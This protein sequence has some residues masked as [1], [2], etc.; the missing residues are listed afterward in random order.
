M[1]QTIINALFHGNVNPWERKVAHNPKR[2]EVERKI[3]TEKEHFLKQM[4]FDD[5]QRFQA[6]ENLYL[7][8]FQDDDVDIF[9][10]GFTLGARMMLEITM[11]RENIAG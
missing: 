2:R 3:E 9:S 4:S 6:L 7:Q 1:N 5:I 10:Y 8:A 11:G